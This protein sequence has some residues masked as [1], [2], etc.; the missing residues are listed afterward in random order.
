MRMTDTPSDA[1]ELP[2]PERPG[3][4]LD[5]DRYAAVALDSGSVVIYDRE[6]P[7]MWLQSDVAVELG[8]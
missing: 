4:A 5:T 7:D 2:E 6:E 3:S 1:D 8:V